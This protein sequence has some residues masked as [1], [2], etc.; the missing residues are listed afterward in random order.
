MSSSAST[1]PDIVD[2]AFFFPIQADDVNSLLLGL[3]HSVRCLGQVGQTGVFC[4]G[5]HSSHLCRQ[6]VEEKGSNERGRVLVEGLDL[7]GELRGRHVPE[8]AVVKKLVILLIL[9]SPKGLDQLFFQC[10]DFARLWHADD[11]RFYPRSLFC[12]EGLVNMV[13]LCLVVHYFPQSKL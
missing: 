7:G 4:V 9:G 6:L 13:E 12:V 11:D 3:H 2:L 8:R 10:Q 1:E 5:Q